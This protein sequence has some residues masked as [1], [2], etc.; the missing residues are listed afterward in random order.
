MK[1]QDL[2]IGRLIMKLAKLDLQT[3]NTWIKLQTLME[4]Y[5]WTFVYTTHPMKIGQFKLASVEKLEKT[6]KEAKRY[7]KIWDKQ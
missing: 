3:A 5:E 7:A 6:I 4:K 1:V 2:K